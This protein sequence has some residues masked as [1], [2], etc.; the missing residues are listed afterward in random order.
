MRV[1]TWNIRHGGSQARL[2]GI[3]GTLVGHQADVIVL[4]EYQ[5]TCGEA[6][7]SGLLQ[8]GWPYQVSSEPPPKTNGVLVAARIPIEVQPRQANM[9]IPHRWVEVCLPDQNLRLVGLHTP[10]SAD[11]QGKKDFWTFV[12]E[13]SAARVNDRC[14]LIGD[15]NTG[16]PLDA[17]GEPFIYGEYMEA[18]TKLGWVDAWRQTHGP[19]KREFTW[20]SSAGNGFRLDYAFLSRGLA[21]HLWDAFHSHPEREQG[22]SDHSALVIELDS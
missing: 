1:V 15:F 2:G 21:R 12:V 3:V 22:V 8:E 20:Y 4:T 5:T 9:P 13:F 11:K 14:V 10:T 19:E 6:I 16:L 7:R 17:E 18:L